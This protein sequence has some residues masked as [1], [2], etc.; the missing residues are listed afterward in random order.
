MSLSERLGEVQ[1]LRM[2]ASWFVETA[3]AWIIPGA[4]AGAFIK[5]VGFEVWQAV[6]AALVVAPLF[7]GAGYMLGRFMW[8]HG[9]TEK[10][11][12]MAMTRDPFKR[13]SL[14]RFE[15]IETLLREIA[16]QVKP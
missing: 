8:Q 11:Y 7:E 12:F 6:L 4:A 1:Y 2:K 14:E 10:E 9:G 13:Q 3:R 5:Y 16:G 15:A